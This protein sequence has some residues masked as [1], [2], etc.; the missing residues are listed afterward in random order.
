MRCLVY[1]CTKSWSFQKYIDVTQNLP[2]SQ[3]IELIC[4]LSPLVK[5]KSL[6]LLRVKLKPCWFLFLFFFLF[7]VLSRSTGDG[8]NNKQNNP[9]NSSQ[10]AVVCQR[11][12]VKPNCASYHP[13][14]L[15]R[16]NSL[17]CDGRVHTKVREIYH[18]F[19][20]LCE[21]RISFFFWQLTLY[22]RE[23]KHCIQK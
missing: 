13:I 16:M 6:I 21:I 7:T 19:A 17:P 8:A 22:P 3:V 11:S 10:A 20:L 9:R 12:K 14:I 2:D 18:D 4:L 23:Q 15:N 1:I 5:F